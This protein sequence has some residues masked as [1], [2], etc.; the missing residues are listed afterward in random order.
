VGDF[1]LDEGS[2]LFAIKVAEKTT[3]YANKGTPLTWICM[4]QTF[5]AFGLQLIPLQS[6][7]EFQIS[8]APT[9]KP[10]ELKWR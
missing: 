7:V 2:V 3:L 4:C 9:Q 6:Q 8:Q 1:Q 5:I 10:N